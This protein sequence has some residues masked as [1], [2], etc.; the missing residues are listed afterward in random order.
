MSRTQKNF[1]A[2]AMMRSV[3][4]RISAEIEGMTLE[5]ELEWLASQELEDPFLKRLRDRSAQQTAAASRAS[6]GR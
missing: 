6:R 4:D 5:E 3:R 1:D 2:V